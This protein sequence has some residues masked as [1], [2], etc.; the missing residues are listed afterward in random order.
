MTLSSAA[1]R[2][3]TVNVDVSAAAEKK[4]SFPVSDCAE[5]G[6]RPSSNPSHPLFQVLSLSLVDDEAS[7]VHPPRKQESAS[8]SNWVGVR[9]EGSFIEGGQAF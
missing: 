6:C 4:T 5:D 8:E 3:P 1:V 7:Y 9:G 2:P